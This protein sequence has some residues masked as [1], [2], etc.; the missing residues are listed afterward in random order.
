MYDATNINS[1]SVTQKDNLNQ[2]DK[3]KVTFHC[4]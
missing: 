4:S 3:R 2:E 1:L